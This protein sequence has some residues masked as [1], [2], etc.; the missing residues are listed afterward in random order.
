MPEQFDPEQFDLMNGDKV[1][2]PSH[3]YGPSGEGMIDV[4]IESS[5]KGKRFLSQIIVPGE[6][7][8]VR[9][10]IYTGECY[11]LRKKATGQ[12]YFL[13]KNDCGFWLHTGSF[14]GAKT[15][16]GDESV[17]VQKWLTGAPRLGATMQL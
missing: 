15:F 16:S 8:A 6:Q 3:R 7:Y 14:Q 9:K 5:D 1:R 17:G 13:D 11:I 12:Y 10:E 2:I 4:W